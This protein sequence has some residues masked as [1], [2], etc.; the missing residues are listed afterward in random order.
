[1]ENKIKEIIFIGNVDYYGKSGQHSFSRN[2][3]KS[4]LSISH[5]HFS[6]KGIF[7]FSS[8]NVESQ[9]SNK[10]KLLFSKIWNRRLQMLI[11]QFYLCYFIFINRKSFFVFSIKPYM[12]SSLFLLLFSCKFITLF[13]GHM[14]NNLNKRFGKYISKIL[15]S[16]V[17][18]IAKRSMSVSVPYI[19][20]MQWLKKKYDLDAKLI[21]CGI[22][23]DHNNYN[24]NSISKN[25]DIVYLG[26]F[27]DIHKIDL[28]IDIIEKHNLSV[29]LIG[30]GKELEKLKSK[31]K[32]LSSGYVKFYGFLNHKDFFSII[33]KS[34]FAWGVVE[35]SH[36]G[37][38]MKV[39]DY[40]SAE[41][42]TIIE[43][44]EDFE[45]LIKFGWLIKLEEF[46][47]NISY[48]FSKN[49]TPK[50]P[51][52]K[53]YIDYKYNWN[54]YSKYILNTFLNDK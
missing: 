44:R 32:N 14:E 20:S 49:Y 12:F 45:E 22:D 9:F 42:I 37:L 36:W 13:E 15:I 8:K 29:G 1:M 7:P 17:I 19:L 21:Y 41:T 34:K 11:F 50:N 46:L 48:F 2:I 28:L 52:N 40:L 35:K 25:H 10:F 39:F 38:P 18:F 53:T 51:I 54:N 5:K 47:K 4:L 30:E 43:P 6:I 27:R 23:F 33:K 31:S 16:Y 26:S 3:A 24:K